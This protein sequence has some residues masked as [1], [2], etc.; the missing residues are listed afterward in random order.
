MKYDGCI[1]GFMKIGQSE[2]M[3]WPKHEICTLCAQCMSK[4]KWK[5][6]KW[7]NEVWSVLDFIF[8]SGTSFFL[9]WV[10]SGG[11]ELTQKRKNEVRVFSSTMTKIIIDFSPTK[12][13]FQ[14]GHK[15]GENRFFSYCLH[16]VWV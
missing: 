7:K 12:T 6:E 4:C 13:L 15:A 2:H 16:G 3:L 14:C 1:L 11:E 8:F 5:N 10:N 9:F